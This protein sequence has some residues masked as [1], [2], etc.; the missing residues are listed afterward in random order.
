MKK[1]NKNKYIKK[2][3]AD[4]HPKTRKAVCKGQQRENP[5][6]CKKYYNKIA[7]DINEGYIS[8]ELNNITFG[9][10]DNGEHFIETA[11]YVPRTSNN[12]DI[13]PVVFTDKIYQLYKSQLHKGRVTLIGTF[14]SANRVVNKKN[15]LF[16]Y[17]QPTSLDFDENKY[18]QRNN[19]LHLCGTVC[20]KPTLKCLENSQIYY[21]KLAVNTPNL[22]N[23]IPVYVRAKKRA[24]DIIKDLKVG[25]RVDFLGRIQS[26]Q[27]HESQEKIRTITE[28]SIAR[29][30]S[31]EYLE[32]NTKITSN[33]ENE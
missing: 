30:N 8:G 25:D 11:I 5:R 4:K 21:F 6:R 3:H 9:F 1:K 31:V 20:N 13:I 28:I 22:D 7:G 17:F 12:V 29:I 14:Q 10:P 2:L 15:T 26:R 32:S 18:K 33:S 23:Y 19:S 24:G 27:Y 16:N